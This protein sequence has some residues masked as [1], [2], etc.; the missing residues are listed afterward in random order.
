MIRDQV[1]ALTDSLDELAHPVVAV[2]EL[3]GQPPADVM[4]KQ[5]DGHGGLKSGGGHSQIISIWF[6]SSGSAGSQPDHAFPETDGYSRTP[7]DRKAAGFEFRR[8]VVDPG[9]HARTHD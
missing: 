5:P 2:G 8:T 3:L 7:K 9:G 1:L 4:A 6:D